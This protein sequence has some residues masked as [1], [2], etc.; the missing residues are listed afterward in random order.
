MAKTK[1]KAK[2][3]AKRAGKGAKAK[4]SAKKPLPKKGVAKKAPAKKGIKKPAPRKPAKPAAK[5]PARKPAK[6]AKPMEAPKE[7]PPMEAPV[8][9]DDGWDNGDDGDKGGG[10]PEGGGIQGGGG[11]H[12]HGGD[13]E[14]GSDIGNLEG[15]AA[16][17]DDDFDALATQGP[18]IA[19]LVGRAMIVQ[20]LGDAEAFF[21]DFSKLSAARRR[22][23]ISHH[24]DAYDQRKHSE[25]KPNW[26]DE[27]I[28]VALLGES[29]PPAIR[30]R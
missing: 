18:R 23:L 10:G 29:M 17:D 5:K 28:P 20:I 22:E 21:F 15:A 11:G 1:S 8:A 6:P 9:I 3:P 13:V 26:T 2:K 19:E 14:G 30:G 25:G 24:A 16:D 4:K 7:A 27:L 12:G